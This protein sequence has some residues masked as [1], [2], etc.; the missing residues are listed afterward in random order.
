VRARRLLRP[1]PGV[2]VLPAAVDDWR[3]RALA[4]RRLA[5]PRDPV[6]VSVR[7][8]RRALSRSGL[9]VHRVQ[10]LVPDRLGPCPVTEPAC[11]L[12][13]T[14]GPAAGRDG[15]RRRSGASSTC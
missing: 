4:V 6:H 8:G 13:D 7:A 10:D 11:A 5:Q 9:V 15:D 1:S 12:V 3:T 2:V 14:W